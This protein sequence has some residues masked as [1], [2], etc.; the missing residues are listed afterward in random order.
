MV[1]LHEAPLN[2]N[3]PQSVGLAIEVLREGFELPRKRAACPGSTLWP[4][5]EGSNYPVP[6]M[7]PRLK[8]PVGG[9][10]RHPTFG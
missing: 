7:V 2:A 6:L 1:V 3:P 8:S 9:R 4:G 10:G 5:P